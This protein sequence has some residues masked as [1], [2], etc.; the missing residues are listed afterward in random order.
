[1]YKLI[2]ENDLFD[3]RG[4]I[5]KN[6]GITEDLLNV[7][8]EAVEDCWDYENMETACELLYNHINKGSKIAIVCDEDTDGFISTTI[9]WRYLKEYHNVEADILLHGKTKAHGLTKDVD[10]PN[11]INLLIVPD[12]SSNNQKEIKE[13]EGKGINVLVLDHHPVSQEI[14]YGVI[15]NNQYS[16]K[17]TNK[18]LCGAG[19]VYKFVTAMSEYVLE[20][21]PIEYMDLNAIANIADVMDMTSKETR[22]YT[23]KGLSEINNP[24]IKSL[25]E[26][27][28]FEIDNK[29]DYIV[30]HSFNTIPLINAVIRAGTIEEKRNLINAFCSDDYSYCL[31]IAKECKRIKQKQDNSVKSSTNKISKFVNLKDDDRIIIVDGM[32]AKTSQ[33]GLIA[34]KIS[35]TFKLPTILY[36]NYNGVCRGSCRGL[37]GIKFKEDLLSSGLVEYIEGHSNACGIGF[38]ENNLKPIKEYM[39]EL[40]KN[41]DFGKSDCYNVDFEL[42]PFDLYQ[43]F[44]DEVSSFEKEVSKGIDWVLVAIKD[45]ELNLNS[46]NEKGKLNVVFDVFGVDCIKKY[47]SKV[48]KENY[49]NK[50]IY[51]DL[52]CKCTVNPYNKKGRLELVDIEVI[53]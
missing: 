22:Y 27:K 49:M 10:I 23:Y 25:I 45:V 51:A 47:A 42:Y 44:V 2:G 31:E 32:D 17:I 35:T 15:V 33:T 52:I 13:L 7:N 50:R 4:Q 18:S 3:I 29:E 21:E 19:V 38:N 36:H 24:F 53:S 9:M 28:S 43:E 41:V 34:S 26:V 40:Y 6:R 39:N 48:W 12:A 37:D 16:D 5:L 8:E 11:D 1:M 14:E 46:S 30:S 20:D